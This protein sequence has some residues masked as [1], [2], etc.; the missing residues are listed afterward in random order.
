[1]NLTC[2]FISYSNTEVKAIVLLL[3]IPWQVLSKMFAQIFSLL[4]KVMDCYEML[5]LFWCFFED[6]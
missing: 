6:P 3:S 4:E 2:L 5:S 1:M